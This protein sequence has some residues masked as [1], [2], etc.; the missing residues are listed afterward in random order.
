MLR[1]AGTEFSLKNASYEIY[2][3]GCYRHCSGCHNPDTQNFEGGKVIERNFM[4]E[5][6]R[7]IYPSIEAGLI[8]NI[9][10]TGGDLLCNDDKEAER[11]SESLDFWFGSL[12]TLWLFTGGGEDEPLPDWVFDYYNVIKIGMYREDMKNPYGTFPASSN[13]RLIGNTKKRSK[14]TKEDFDKIEF[15]GVKIWN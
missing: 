10:V 14:F 1:L 11:F 8:K 7:K 9:Y 2:I 6:Y 13:Q 12:V 4:K 3:Q 15:M 5:L